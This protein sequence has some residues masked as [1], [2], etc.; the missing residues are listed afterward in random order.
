MTW[1]EKSSNY[2]RHQDKEQHNQH[3]AETSYEE[4][5]KKKK[6]DRLLYWNLRDQQQFHLLKVDLFAELVT[7]TS[8]SPS[9]VA[10]CQGVVRTESVLTHLHLYQQQKLESSGRFRNL[11]KGVQ[12]L[13]REAHPKILGLAPSST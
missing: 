10:T 5:N 3:P 9:T 6:S 1:K 12:P 2:H 4:T 7:S 8:A 11:E 13:A